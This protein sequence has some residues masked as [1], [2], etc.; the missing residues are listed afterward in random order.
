MD[1]DQDWAELVE[2]ERLNPAEVVAW[3]RTPEDRLVWLGQSN[4]KAGFKHIVQEHGE[5]K[6][7]GIN[8]PIWGSRLKSYQSF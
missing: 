1:P 3:T 7:M 2:R 5:S 6:S 4:G 8:W